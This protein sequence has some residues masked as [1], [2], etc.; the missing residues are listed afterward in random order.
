[1]LKRWSMKDRFFFLFDRMNS[2]FSQDDIALNHAACKTIENLLLV[3]DKQAEKLATMDVALSLWNI[4]S[5]VGNNEHLR[6][7]ALGVVYP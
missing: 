5:I 4:A 3:S 2:F 1:M 6:A 7:S